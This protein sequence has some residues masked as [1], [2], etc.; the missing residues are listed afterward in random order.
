MGDIAVRKPGFNI[1]FNV[2]HA[3]VVTATNC[4]TLRCSG[5]PNSDSTKTF[6]ANIM[7][8]G[9][10]DDLQEWKLRD[11][12][13]P[14]KT[15]DPIYL[16]WVPGTSDS[17]LAG[18]RDFHKRQNPCSYDIWTDKLTSGQFNGQTPC[19]WYCSLLVWRAYLRY[20]QK[21]LDPGGGYWVW[22][23]DLV[24]SSYTSTYYVE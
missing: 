5:N 15:G 13:D 21:D 24:D 1:T 12:F 10:S 20:T 9:T 6:E 17:Q 2:G 3:G 16:L 8:S 14:A 22:P 23:Y 4:G 19:T 11:Q 7:E 18:I